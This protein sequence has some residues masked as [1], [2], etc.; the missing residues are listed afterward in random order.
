MAYVGRETLSSRILIVEDNADLRRV[1]IEILQYEGYSAVST[2][3]AEEALALLANATE[4]PNLV[5]SDI[6]LEGMDGCAFLT[7]VRQTEGLQTLPVLFLSGQANAQNLCGSDDLKPDA[8][9][10]K[11]FTIQDLVTTIKQTIE[12]SETAAD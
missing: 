9:V 10:E 1:L 4:R 2:G 11:P 12:Q 6:V 5:I 3:S 8:Y 7:A